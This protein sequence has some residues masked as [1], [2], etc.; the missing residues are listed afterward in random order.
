MGGVS[1][2]KPQVKAKKRDWCSLPDRV[3]QPVALGR[4]ATTFTSI[5]VTVVS[6]VAAAT[7]RTSS[8]PKKDSW[9]A[10][11]GCSTPMRSTP[12]TTRSGHASAAM[13]GPTISSQREKR[14]LRT[15][16]AGA[17]KER[18]SAGSES[19]T[20]RGSGASPG[21]GRQ[22]LTAEFSPLDPHHQLRMGV[23]RQTAGGGDQGLAG[24]ERLDQ[25]RCTVS[26]ELGEHVV[27]QQQR[28][29][30]QL[31]VT[32]Q[33]AGQAQGQGQ[34]ALLALGG[35]GARGQAAQGHD[36]VVALGPERW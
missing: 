12:S 2:G 25:G 16:G 9:V 32:E 30:A 27:E 20:G 17:P 21:S 31:P 22:G 10:H 14:E 13:A 6:P 7:L 18:A 24:R 26:V 15:E 34:G 1:A 23:G 5:L 8:G 36:Q 35:V 29:A 19:P 4:R 33:V 28:G 3:C 11:A